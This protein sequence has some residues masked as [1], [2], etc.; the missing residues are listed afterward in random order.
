VIAFQ[1]KWGIITALFG[2]DIEA[3]LEVFT[4]RNVHVALF[5]VLLW[6]TASIGQQDA[7]SKPLTDSLKPPS[8]KTEDVVTDYFGTKVADPYRWMERASEVRVLEFLKSQNDYTRSVLGS[9]AGRDAML[10]RIQQLD[11][12][13]PTVLSW[14][15]GGNSI[16]YLETGPGATTASLLVRDAAGHSRTLLDPKSLEQGASHA[17]IDYFAPSGDGHYVIAGVSLGGSENSTIHVVEVPSGRMLP[18]AITRTQ[19]A[20]PSWRSD[21][22][23]FYYSRLQQLGPGAPPTA[24][25]ENERVYLHVIG[26]NVENDAVVFGPAVS[27]SISIPKAGFVGVGVTP[28]SNYALAIYSAGT[29]DPA[30]L[31]L[32]PS[33]KARDATAP[34][35]KIASSEDLIS[36]GAASNIA[37]HESTLYLLVD[38][39]APNR[40][41]VSVDLRHPDIANATL[42]VPPSDAVLVGVYAAADGIY[43]ESKRGVTFELQRSGYEPQLKWEKISLPYDGTISAV[44][45]NVL[46]PGIIF[47]LESWTQSDQ[48]FIYDPSSNQVSNTALIEKDPVD[49]SRYEAR[50]VEATS[51]D[52]T[53]VPLSILCRK[54]LVLDGSHPT[55]YEGYGAYG[56]SFD[57]YFDPRTMAWLEKG[58]VWA[59]VHVRGGGEF[60]ESWH[61]AG[62]KETKQHTIDDMVAAAQYLIQQGYT[63]PARL[64]VR[65]TSAGGIAVGGAIVDH[66]E[67]FVAAID[68]VGMTDLLRFQTTQGGAA[69]VPEFGDV[70]DPA[71]FRYLYAVSPYHHVVDQTR[72]PAVL[73]ITG[74]NDPRVPSWVVAKMIARLQA[75]S[76]SGRAILL[77]VDFDEGHGLGSSRP[78]RERLMADQ[79]SFILWQ[80]GDP[81]F[82]PGKAAGRH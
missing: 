64:A 60:G 70:T 49:F 2:S 34:W 68:N 17:A 56:V 57:P 36:P 52:G 31:Y 43:L 77:R 9:L 26:N 47:R 40:K 13:V 24:I 51:G 42:L 22:R 69:N 72:Y 73:G 14:Q 19:Y 1:A 11:N 41:L 3:R 25:Y 37:I 76:S 59:I 20:G 18:D 58:G 12:A 71:G 63:S 50:E 10:A 66:P 75:A 4:I 27:S 55:L 21:S 38:K 67:L 6:C 8:A 53:K 30:S 23:S 29:T 65:G 82:Q 15:R 46:L 61:N 5:F 80:S 39:G 79:F 33:E 74:T 16:F 28:G 32:A 44:D 35:R 7:D 78:Q 45:A 62:R 48:A 54:D 81:E